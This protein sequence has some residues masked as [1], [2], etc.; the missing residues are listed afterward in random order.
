MT[1]ER[2][3]SDLVLSVGQV[4]KIQTVDAEQLRRLREQVSAL[5]QAV[6]KLSREVK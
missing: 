5:D 1:F 3:M 4:M 2:I 6:V